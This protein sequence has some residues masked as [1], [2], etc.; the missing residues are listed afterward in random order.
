L[1]WKVFLTTFGMIFLAELGDKTQL[2]AIS[3]S[4][5]TKMPFAVFWGAIAAL[6]VITLIGVLVGGLLTKVVPQFY[7]RIGSGTLFVLVGTLILTG[8]FK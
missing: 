8:F 2:A 4:S 6:G 5:E 1:D 7:I 3:M